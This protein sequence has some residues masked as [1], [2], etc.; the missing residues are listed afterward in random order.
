MSSFWSDVFSDMS[1]Y[2]DAMEWDVEVHGEYH[3]NDYYEEE[4]DHHEEQEHHDEDQPGIMAPEE[5]LH[6]EQ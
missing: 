4:E 1:G 6:T 3:H 5:M 2:D